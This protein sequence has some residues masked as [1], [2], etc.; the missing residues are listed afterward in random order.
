MILQLFLSMKLGDLKCPYCGSEKIEIYDSY[1]TD[2]NGVR[3]LYDCAACLKSFSETKGTFMEGIK[4]PISKIALVLKARSEG[5]GFNA[6][7]R[8]FRIGRNTLAKWEKRFAS[9]RN[10]LFMY[11]LTFSFVS[12]IIEGDE[13]YTKV[14]KNKP[15]HESEG[16]TIVLMDRASRFIWDIQCGMKNRELFLKVIETLKDVIE[17]SEELILLTDG[18]RRYGNI[19][20]EICYEVMRT[21]KPG[22]PAKVL[23]KG[24][25][26]RLKNK[27]SQSH[28]RGRK[29]PKYEAPVREHPDT[30]Q[31]I[32]DEDIHADHV[33]AF[34]AS[35]R[36]RNSTCRRKTNTYAKK[37]SAL[38]RTLDIGWI[39]HNFITRHFTTK[40]VPAVALGIL[41]KGLS[42]E[43]IFAIQYFV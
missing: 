24:V 43:Q 25:K 4:K 40:K 22:R 13:F 8:T 27:G 9:I 33:E 6:T 5:L 39:I 15:V 35:N 11:A 38:Q 19:L 42:I 41:E 10:I 30:K 17:R 29:R 26:V 31:D 28:K 18:E 2:Q 37:K 12:Q 16:W 1:K 23:P 34:N 3:N 32:C 36:R 7:C 21:K 20:F 14:G